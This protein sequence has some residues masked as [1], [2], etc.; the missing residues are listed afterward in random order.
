MPGLMK[1]FTYGSLQIPRIMRAVTGHRYPSEPARL[2]D[3]ARYCLIGRSYQGIRRQLG[4]QTD[5]LIYLEVDTLALQRL[6]AFEDDFYHRETVTV[7]LASGGTT[8]AE[9]YVVSPEHD[10]LLIMSQEWSLD[11]L[12]M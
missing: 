2:D 12:Q 5:G 3:F 6:D 9:V 11:H 7:T 10:H 8:L 4:A 1:V